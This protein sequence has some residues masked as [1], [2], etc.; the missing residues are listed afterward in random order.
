MLK[1]I[2]MLSAISLVPTAG[3]ALSQYWEVER[4][5]TE[6][7]RLSRDAEDTTEK[8]VLIEKQLE[9]A[10]KSN[11]KKS[12]EIAARNRELVQLR[13]DAERLKSRIAELESVVATNPKK[14]DQAELL[15]L[16]AFMTSVEE[17]IE[18]QSRLLKGLADAVPKRPS[19]YE[20]LTE[21]F[22]DAIR[23]TSNN[24]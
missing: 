18:S 16:R 19:R 23:G 15:K 2:A 24:E 5:K 4:L 11:Q 8:R 9:E 6:V 1:A 17:Y 20:E 12:L 14:V 21:K 3:F 7:N 13:S 10:E 22:K